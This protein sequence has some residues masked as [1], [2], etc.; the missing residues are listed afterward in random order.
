MRQLLDWLLVGDTES[1]GKLKG[2][3]KVVPSSMAFL[4]KPPLKLLAEVV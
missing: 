2:K 4:M 1:I 3:G